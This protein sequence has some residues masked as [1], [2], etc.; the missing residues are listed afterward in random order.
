MKQYRT[1]WISDVHLGT[2]G[3][4]AEAL[5]DF[6]K[7]YECVKLCRLGDSSA[8]GPLKSGIPWPQSHNEVVQ[9]LLRKAR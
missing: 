5:L 9:I 4:Q 7:T 3:C 1:M 8:S 2:K 6:I